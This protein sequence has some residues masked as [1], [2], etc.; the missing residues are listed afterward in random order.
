MKNNNGFKVGF[1]QIAYLLMTTILLIFM[2]LLFVDSL[3]GPINQECVKQA[4]SNYIE[5]CCE[6]EVDVDGDGYYSFE[7]NNL[8][9]GDFAM[10]QNME[11]LSCVCSGY[12]PQREH[13]FCRDNKWFWFF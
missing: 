13:M 4:R 6:G 7:E 5:D 12:H 8:G 9:Y 11:R 10:M 1:F 2:I 3:F